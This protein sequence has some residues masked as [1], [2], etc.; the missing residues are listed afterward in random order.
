MSATLRQW[1]RDPDLWI[2]RASITSQLRAKKT[3]DTALLAAVLEANLADP[4]FFIRKAMR[5]PDQ[6]T[7]RLQDVRRRARVFSGTAGGCLGPRRSGRAQTGGPST[8]R[9]PGPAQGR[10]PDPGSGDRGRRQAGL[11]WRKS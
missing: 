7:V 2:R 10:S 4:E 6:P 8:L 9:Q 11:K 3:T 1:S 5:L